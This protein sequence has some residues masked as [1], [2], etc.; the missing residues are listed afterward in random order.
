MKIADQYSQFF[1]EE[2]FRMVF[3]KNFVNRGA[4][5]EEVK[6]IIAGSLHPDKPGMVAATLTIVRH[7]IEDKIASVAISAMDLFEV[8]VKKYKPNSDPSGSL[9]P[10]L[11]KVFDYQAHNSDKVKKV[12]N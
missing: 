4:G 7:T 9:D 6:S 3:S 11:Q 2:V 8:L 5:L 1:S 12:A 10:I